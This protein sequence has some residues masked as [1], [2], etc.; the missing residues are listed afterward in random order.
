MEVTFTLEGDFP[1]TGNFTLSVATAK[2]AGFPVAL[3]VPDW[4]TNFI[5]KVGSKVYRGTSGQFVTINKNW[6]PG[7]KITIRFDMPVQTVQGGKSYPNQI[8]YRRGPQVLAYDNSLNSENTNLFLSNAKEKI[9]IGK[10]LASNVDKVLPPN[11]I[12][13]QAY[14][15]DILNKN[16][17]APTQLFLVPFADASQTGGDMRVWLP[18]KEKK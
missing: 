16:E 12:G 6:K 14:S 18:V 15:F 3:R 7:E 9:E 11:W 2:P 17:T 8:A 4:C 13:T 5:A 10:I 1:E